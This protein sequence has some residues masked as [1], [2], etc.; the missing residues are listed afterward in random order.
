MS[1]RALCMAIVA[2]LRTALDLN[3]DECEF[4]PDGRPKPI[5][6]ETF[7]SVWCGDWQPIE[8]EGLGETFSVNV[9]LT[10]RLGYV[11]GDRVQTEVWAKATEG[12][13][14]KLRQI[15]TTIV[16]D[17]GSSSILNTANA[18][19]TE[20]ANK[21]VTRLR[22]F[23]GGRPEMQGPDWFGADSEVGDGNFYNA[24]LSQTLSFGGAERYQTME[25]MV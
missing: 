13:E 21:F 3:S 8:C 14:A 5:A 9:T 19:I 20:T 22:M 11:P 10:R 24:G 12:M 18:L 15:V 23:S 6:G 4:M 2:R 16:S 1:Q 17:I 25:S 7:V